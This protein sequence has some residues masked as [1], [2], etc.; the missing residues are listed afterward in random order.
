M[1]TLTSVDIAGALV[2][3][4]E[5]THFKEVH[6]AVLPSSDKEVYKHAEVMTLRPEEQGTRKLFVNPSK[7]PKGKRRSHLMEEDWAVLCQALFQSIKEDVWIEMHEKL[8]RGHQKDW[9][10]EGWAEG[11]WSR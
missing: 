2:T 9:I 11:C 5:L 1:A 8:K 3:M 10:K 6:T 4:G 7:I